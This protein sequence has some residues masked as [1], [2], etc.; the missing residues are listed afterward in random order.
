MNLSQYFTSRQSHSWICIAA[1]L[2][3]VLVLNACLQ[4]SERLGQLWQQHVVPDLIRQRSLWLGQYRFIE[5]LQLPGIDANASDIVYIEAVQRYFVLVNNPP[6]LFEYSED[7]KLK[8]RHDLYGFEDPEA[9]AYDHNG[10]LLIAEERH[11]TVVR[12][13]LDQLT[14]PIVRAEL[15][16]LVLDERAHNNRGLEGIAFDPDSAVLFASK[17]KQPMR[18]FGVAGYSPQMSEPAP[19]PLATDASALAL[20]RLR[21]SDISALHY[22]LE[23][24]HLLVLSHESQRLVEVDSGYA[25]LSHLDLQRGLHGL[26]ESVPQAEGVTLGPQREIMIVSEPNLLYRYRY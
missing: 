2:L 5:R 13:S 1:V 22:D 17:E 16:T 3:L 9:L 14:K 6:V 26:D 8:A 12:V 10:H 19:R 4:V 21:I 15:P 11:Q 18:L 23:T 20:W 7:F 24:K 25:Q